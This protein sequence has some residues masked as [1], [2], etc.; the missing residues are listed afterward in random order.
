M[1][2][3]CPHCGPRDLREF[4]YLGDGTLERPDPAAPNALD[5]FVEYVYFRDNPAGTHRELWYHAH[6]C[7]AWL[8]VIRD[9]RDHAISGAHSC[10]PITVAPRGRG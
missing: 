6:G 10:E 8:V 1:R 3:P 2:I 4:V 7:Q 5:R 9:T